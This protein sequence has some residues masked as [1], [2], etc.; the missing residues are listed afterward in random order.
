MIPSNT[1]VIRSCRNSLCTKSYTDHS[2]TQA[3]H[4]TNGW[5]I[6]PNALH[7]DQNHS[8][9]QSGRT[10]GSVPILLTNICG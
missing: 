4:A 5:M 8:V 9:A 10:V 2:H 6:R 1:V 3:I 7:P